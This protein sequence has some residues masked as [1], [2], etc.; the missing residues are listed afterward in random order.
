MLVQHTMTGCNL[1]PG[2]LIAT[3][4]I[5]GQTPDSYGSMLELSW[6]GS[7]PI[8]LDENLTRKFLEDGDTVIMTGKRQR[9]KEKANNYNCVIVGFYQGNGFRIGFDECVGTVTPAL[10]LPK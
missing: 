10:P 5:S 1:R 7:K 4:T 6:R 8:Q 9:E 3:G 2:D